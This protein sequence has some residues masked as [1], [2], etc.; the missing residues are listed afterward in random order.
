MFK[1]SRIL[2]RYYWEIGTLMGTNQ[3]I[4]EILLQMQ[5]FIRPFLRLLNTV[6]VHHQHFFFFAFALLS[7]NFHGHFVMRSEP[8]RNE[9]INLL[10]WFHFGIFNAFQFGSHQFVINL[11]NKWLVK[12]LILMR[13]TIDF[14][15]KDMF[16]A[17]LVL[18]GATTFD[19]LFRWS[20]FISVFKAFWTWEIQLAY[21]AVQNCFRNNSNNSKQILSWHFLAFFL[22]ILHFFIFIFIRHRSVRIIVFFNG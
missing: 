10:E 14:W 3:Y 18:S 11:R 9:P 13:D 1:D 4:W 22:P 12:C 16:S 2:C 5:R 6:L 21:S 20:N 17:H 15:P 19:H 7:N 8:V